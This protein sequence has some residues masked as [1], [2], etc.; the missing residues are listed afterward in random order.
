[1]YSPI[2]E[3]KARLDIVDFIQGYIRLQKTGSNYR[4]NCPFHGEKTPSF[5]VSSQRQIWHCF[6][7]GKGG[8]IFKFIMEMDGHDFPEAL[9]MLADKAGVVIKREDP[10][11]RSERN[12]LYEIC[13]EAAKIFEK[14]FWLTSTIHEYIKKRGV[15]D[16]TLKKFRVG[17]APASWD[18]L[19]KALTQKGFKREEVLRAGLAIQSDDRSSFYDRFRNRIMFPIEDNNGRVIGFGGR[20]SPTT[21]DEK[22]IKEAKYVN[23]PATLIYDKSRVLYGYENAKNEIR[24]QNRVV[25]VEGYM[26]CIMSHQA[27]IKNTI[28]VS[29]T[30]LTPQQLKTLRRVCETMVS[31]FDADSAGESATRRSLLLAGEFDFERRVAWIPSGKDPADAVLENPEHWRAAVAEAKPVIQFYF[32][33]AFGAFS[34]STVNGKKSISQML[35]P[36]VAELGNKI[37]QAHWVSELS[38]RLGLAEESIWDELKKKTTQPMQ[39]KTATQE[40][41]RKRTRREI[42]EDRLLSLLSL[43]KNGITYKGAPFLYPFTSGLHQELFAALSMNLDLSPEMEKQAELFRFKGEVLVTLIKDPVAEMI[44]CKKELEKEYVKEELLQLGQEIG[45]KE[46][47]GDATLV[48]SLLQNFQTL[49]QRLKELG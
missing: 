20:I 44:L 18:Y 22:A 43:D 45:K 42:L 17:F 1:M 48:A 47:Q 23:T 25:V 39:H 32:D 5:F 24:T 35:L 41:T 7:C 33:K 49:S 40:K 37:E 27:G 2:E 46:I 8:D 34:S 16:E 21:T 30:A 4:A 13:D 29:G 36:W 14:S 3:I 10:S 11:I 12:R 26:D 28:A 38:R 9:R 6:G 15:A 19:L 31:S